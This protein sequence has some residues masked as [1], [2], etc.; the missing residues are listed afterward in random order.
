VSPC[1]KI[2]SRSGQTNPHFLSCIIAGNKS[3]VFQYKPEA[4]LRMERGTESSQMPR[5]F[6]LQKSSTKIMLIIFYDDKVMIYEEYVYEGRSMKTQV[7]E[8]LLK[9]S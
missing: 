6:H 1:A 8:R 9:Q 3:W 5:N 2:A 7:L 4:S